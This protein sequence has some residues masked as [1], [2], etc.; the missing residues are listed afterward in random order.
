MSEKSWFKIGH[1]TQENVR[2]GCTAIVFDQ[3]VPAAVDSRGGAPGT[4]ETTLLEPGN[5][6]MLDAILLSG[7]SA[8]G[9]QATDGVMRYLAE[10]DRGFETRFGKVPLVSSAIIFDLGVGSAYHPTVD[11]GYAA[12]AS[13]VA[14]NS[15]TGPIGAGCGAT[16][17]KLGGNALPSGIGWAQV[18]ID[19]FYVSAIVVLNAV[20]D[21][22]KPDTGEWLA[23]ND[24]PD[25]RDV[26]IGGLQ[27]ADP[28]ENTTIGAVLIDGALDRRSLARACISAQAAL[29]RCTIPAHTVLDGDTFYAAS[30]S[31]GQPTIMQ[32]LAVTSAVEVA[33][34]RAIVSVFN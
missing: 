30:S 7:G 27:R 31:A 20:G 34:E 6:G 1:T 15:V 29:A 26:A 5:V 28:L 2:S 25:C 22:R 32:T 12:A 11:D 3:Q 19:D 4:R 33:V 14:G 10:Q 8:F 13:A 16:V 21:V 18:Q 17:A 23:R 24:G 9:L